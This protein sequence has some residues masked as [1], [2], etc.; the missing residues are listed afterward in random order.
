MSQFSLLGKM[1]VKLKDTEN[2]QALAKR[3]VVL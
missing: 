2:V 1:P 3:K